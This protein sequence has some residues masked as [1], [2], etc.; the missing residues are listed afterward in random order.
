MRK[1]TRHEQRRRL[2]I[3]FI[4]L[5]IVL[6]PSLVLALDASLRGDVFAG[7]V[8]MA[9][10]RFVRWV[11]GIIVVGVV[12]IF[13]I[14]DHADQFK[15]LRETTYRLLGYDTETI[16]ERERDFTEV[17]DDYVPR[18]ALEKQ[19]A[20]ALAPSRQLALVVLHGERD[21]GK[22]TLLHYVVSRRLNR[23]Y[24]GRIIYCRGDRHSIELEPDETDAQ[25]RHKLA[26]RVLTRII[27]KA[28][29]PG[30]IG[31]GMAAMSAAVDAHFHREDKPWLLIIDQ[32]DEALFPYAEVLPTLY[33]RRNTVVIACRHPAIGDGVAFSRDGM[34]KAAK[35]DV[36]MQAFTRQQA[37]E[38]LRSELRKRRKRIDLEDLRLLEHHLDGTSPGIIQRLSDAYAG[39]QELER[40]TSAL[41]PTAHGDE[42]GRIFAIAELTVEQL[43]PPE[44]IFVTALSILSGDTVAAPVLDFIAQRLTYDDGA[45]PPDLIQ[46]C[47]KRGYLIPDPR[48]RL[49]RER[50][51]Y[52]ITKLGRGIARVARRRGGLEEHLTAGAALLDFYRGVEAGAVQL[53]LV[54]SLPNIV[55]IM[56]W[57]QLPPRWLPES[58]LISFTR[59]LKDVYYIAGTWAVGTRWLS[60]G[61]AAAENQRRPRAR[62]DLTAARARLYL[63]QGMPRQAL[64]DAVA[65]SHAFVASR[66]HTES[67][68]RLDVGDEAA[69]RAGIQY[70][71]LQCAWLTHL[72]ARA[73]TLRLP[74]VTDAAEVERIAGCV[75]AGQTMLQAITAI[76]S[77]TPTE[78]RTLAHAA[79]LALQG[80]AVEI[81]LVEG[82]RAAAT[83]ASREARRYW[84]VARTRAAALRRAASSSDDRADLEARALA[85]RL[86]AAAC[87]RR[88]AGQPVLLRSF[89]RHR[90]VRALSRSRHVCAQMASRYDEGLALRD[91]ARLATA[92]TPDP[93]VDDPTRAE[94]ARRPIIR[95]LLAR[96][97]PRWRR[98]D[99]A[100]HVLRAAHASNTI[101][102]AQSAQVDVL[103]ALADL[104]LRLWMLD[105]DPTRITDARAY[106]LA[107][108]SIVERLRA[109]TPE[110]IEQVR[111]L[112]LWLLPPQ[113]LP[114]VPPVADSTFEL[115]T[116]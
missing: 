17:P 101:L 32:V 114:S 9:S 36:P 42:E 25:A 45:S 28:E 99:G 71:R 54:R 77:Q 44:R 109:D 92:G 70:D 38:L 95:A 74:S 81:A 13:E 20:G 110:L 66:E 29:V 84:A 51:R 96:I 58:A 111:S 37:T 87:R 105:R 27:D 80:D 76:P 31:E 55:S 115:S 47:V 4:L 108:H 75:R 18:P 11:T 85:W 61:I 19:L 10:L 116:V 39:H 3:A 113:D 86:E 14:A 102:G 49:R 78:L 41:D 1:S 103:V 60:S 15:F 2:A 94:H 79:D 98:Y 64:A 26:K 46:M 83:G 52:A 68:L 23:A 89:W 69:L 50:Q 82:D 35:T 106:A 21:S 97:K 59:M 5:G 16:A 48:R 72:E 24:R 90:G 67:D 40:V 33:G 63:A 12:L 100:L 73:R 93:R 6:V 53:D 7:I 43:T 91:M 62:G 56:A 57:S 107:A 112:P 34:L 22:T 65:A 8:H 30:D 88:I 104:M